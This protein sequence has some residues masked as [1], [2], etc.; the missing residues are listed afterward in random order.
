MTTTNAALDDP[1]AMTNDRWREEFGSQV[2]E[3]AQRTGLVLA[4]QAGIAGHV[5]GQDRR[6]SALNALGHGESLAEAE[7]DGNSGF[8]RATQAAPNVAC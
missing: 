1:A 8:T 4:H 7:K 2:S 3:R 6:Q 5:S